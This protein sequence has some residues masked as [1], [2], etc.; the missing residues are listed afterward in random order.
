MLSADVFACDA[1]L[2]AAV[3]VWFGV[4][5]LESGS[6]S[7]SEA[8]KHPGDQQRAGETGRLWFGADLQLPHGA[9]TSGKRRAVSYHRHRS[10]TNTSDD[11]FS[12]QVVTLWYRSPEVL[13]QTTYATPVDIWSTG[14][15][16]AEMFRRT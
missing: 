7:G 15:I 4:L 2:D 1:G 8:G 6:P 10:H 12:A 16:F 3:A 9:H 11:V 13:L 5:A 14:C